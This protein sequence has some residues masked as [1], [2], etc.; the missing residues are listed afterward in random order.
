[1][2]DELLTI[3]VDTRDLIAALDRLGDEAERHVKAAAKVTADRIVAEARRRVARRADPA[4]RPTDRSGPTA[5]LIRAEET[6]DGLGY[7]VLANDPRSREHVARYLEF[8]TTH[9]AARPFFFTSARLEEAAHLRRT[10]QALQDAIDAV[11]L[12]S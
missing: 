9:M 5:D 1:M 6:H 8:G 3:E 2:A 10:E 12:G 7:I 11:G 4:T